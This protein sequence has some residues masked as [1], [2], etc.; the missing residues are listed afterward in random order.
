[1]KEGNTTLSVPNDFA[2]T[3]RSEF[4]GRN[5]MERLENWADR[6]SND[7]YNKDITHEDILMEIKEIEIPENSN[8]LTQQE[9]KK[10]VELAL[11]SSSY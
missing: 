7:S 6:H 9:V 1:M 10:A 4:N 2:D 8:G 3:L 11:P 5:D